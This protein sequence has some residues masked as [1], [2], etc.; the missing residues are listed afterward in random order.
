MTTPFSQGGPVNPG[1]PYTVGERGPQLFVPQSH[2]KPTEPKRF[3]VDGIEYDSS[4]QTGCGSVPH[5]SPES[6]KRIPDDECL[7]GTGFVCLAH[8]LL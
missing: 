7:C 3:V 5:I 1:Q 4:L 2:A 6:V 8:P